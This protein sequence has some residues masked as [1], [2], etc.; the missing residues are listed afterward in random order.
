LAA[1]PSGASTAT[2]S[3]ALPAA[4]LG[5]VPGVKSAPF[6][7]HTVTRMPHDDGTGVLIPLRGSRSR[8]SARKDIG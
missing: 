5:T 8:A 4:L 2:S 7:L 3:C 1:H 6:N